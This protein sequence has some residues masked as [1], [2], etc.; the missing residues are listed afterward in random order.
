[1]LDH[2]KSNLVRATRTLWKDFCFSECHLVGC[3]MTLMHDDI[4]GR[5]WNPFPR[6]KTFLSTVHW[7]AKK[8]LHHRIHSCL[9]ET[10]ALT[11]VAALV[12]QNN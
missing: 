4:H 10:P 3:S 2:F 11:S 7:E 5:L 1:M 6:L 8:M 9:P 12:V